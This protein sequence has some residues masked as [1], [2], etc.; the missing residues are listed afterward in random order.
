MSFLNQI[1]FLVLHLRFYMPST[2]IRVLNLTGPCFF[3]MQV[4]RFWNW[5]EI[6]LQEILMKNERILAYQM[7]QKLN[8]SDIENVSGGLNWV[9]CTRPSGNYNCRGGGNNS[10]DMNYNCSGGV[11]IVL[12]LA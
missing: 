4:L 11:D 10:N 5:R 3:M 9:S 12:D 1:L 7:S 8:S 2:P 6:I